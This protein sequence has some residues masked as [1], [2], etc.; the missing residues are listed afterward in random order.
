MIDW[1][2]NRY[3]YLLLMILSISYPLI[4]S[5]ENKIRFYKNWKSL[6]FAISIMMTIFITWDVIFTNLSVWS[7]NDRY[8]LGY[9]FLNLPIEEW[10]FFICIPGC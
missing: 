6:V 5:F 8:I 10:M 2:D 9:K 7:F 1:L 3:Y 4:R